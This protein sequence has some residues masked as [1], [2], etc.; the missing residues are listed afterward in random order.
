MWPTW[1]SWRHD[2]IPLWE[3]S[4]KKKQS[5]SLRGLGSLQWLPS[6][7]LG[8][9]LQLRC[10]FP[11]IR[12]TRPRRWRLCVRTVAEP[13]LQHGH[14]NLIICDCALVVTILYPDYDLIYGLVKSIVYAF[15]V[16]FP[17]RIPTSRIIP[18]LPVGGF[19]MFQLPW[20]DLSST[21]L[22][23]LTIIPRNI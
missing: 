3:T 5:Q 16:S 21:R 20:T 8:N 2:N 15:F 4:C 7:R 18:A 13:W 17:P 19:N 23:I 6:Y 22:R 9:L 12:H 14:M 10:S 1:R 11:A